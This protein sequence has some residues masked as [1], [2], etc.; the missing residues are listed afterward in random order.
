MIRFTKPDARS[1]DNSSYGLLSFPYVQQPDFSGGES[2]FL[3]FLMV[4]ECV[5]FV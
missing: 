4:L 2:I 1:L 5:G 3:G